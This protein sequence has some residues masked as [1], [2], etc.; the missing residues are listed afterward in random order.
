MILYPAVDLMGGRVVRLAQGRFEDATTYA[1]DPGEALAAFAAAGATWAHVVDL[2]GARAGAPV[3]HDLIARLAATAPLDLQVAGGVR[4]RDQIARLLGTGAA[5]VAVGSLAVSQPGLVSEWLAEFGDRL[6]L[7][8]DVRLVAGIPMVATSGWTR[9]SGRSLWD[10]A[11]LYPEARHLLLTDI[12][13]DGMLQG[14]N[15]ALLEEAVARLPR[16]AVQASGGI[17]SLE[18]LTRLTTAGAIVGKALWEGRFSLAEALD[19]CA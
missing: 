3:Q 15:F 16:V 14:P 17:S 9:D 13:R 7:S 11:A 12:G 5:R 6:T 4:T 8:L 10:V 19:A 1:A 2:D 18:D